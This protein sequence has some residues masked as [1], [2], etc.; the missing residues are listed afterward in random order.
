GLQHCAL[1]LC[2][3]R[4]GIER[5]YSSISDGQLDGVAKVFK[6]DKPDSGFRYFMGFLW[7]P[8]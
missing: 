2:R 8:G 4:Y 1:R 6:A 5:S 7:K 3:R